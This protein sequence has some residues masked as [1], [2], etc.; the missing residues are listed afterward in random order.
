MGKCSLFLKDQLS[1]IIISYAQMNH[2]FKSVICCLLVRA[3]SILH[4]ASKDVA[5][6]EK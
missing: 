3:V 2:Q 6:P 4:S 1:H 5:S